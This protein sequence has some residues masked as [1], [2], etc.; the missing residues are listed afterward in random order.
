MLAA[1]L[2]LSGEG[3]GNYYAYVAAL[4]VRAELQQYPGHAAAVLTDEW[5]V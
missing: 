4:S 5:P 3:E 1:R 2:S